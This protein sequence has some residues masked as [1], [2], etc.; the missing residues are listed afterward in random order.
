MDNTGQKRDAAMKL[1]NVKLTN[2]WTIQDI[3]MDQ[4]KK[5]YRNVILT[6][7]MMIS[8]YIMANAFPYLR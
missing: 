8:P 1:L 4:I 7:G 2:D 3:G 6:S 5:G